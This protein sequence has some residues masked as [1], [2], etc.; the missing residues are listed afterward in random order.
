MKRR[1]ESRRKE[2]RRKETR[3]KERKEVS[4]GCDEGNTA[5]KDIRIFTMILSSSQCLI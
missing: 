4:R 1:K 3:R 5:K 2:T